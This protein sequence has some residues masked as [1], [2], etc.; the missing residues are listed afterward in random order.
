VELL[1]DPAGKRVAIG[2][3]WPF[4]ARLPMPQHRMS[5]KKR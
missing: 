5:E 3:T 1:S 4:S 2:D